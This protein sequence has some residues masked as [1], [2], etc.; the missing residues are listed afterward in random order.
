MAT[1]GV[2]EFPPVA[3]PLV[4][5]VVLLEHVP[6]PLVHEES[7]GQEHHLVEGHQH[8]EVDVALL[9][10]AEGLQQPNVFE[11]SGRGDAEGQ[12]VPHRLVET[13]KRYEGTFQIKIKLIN[14]KW[15][16]KI[17]QNGTLEYRQERKG[18]AIQGARY[19]FDSTSSDMPFV[20]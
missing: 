16:L 15:K 7:E 4:R 14:S 9:V 2:P 5:S 13:F 18:K 6:P 12:H 1:K 20:A 11:M 8:Q 3:V 10:D 17:S 19:A